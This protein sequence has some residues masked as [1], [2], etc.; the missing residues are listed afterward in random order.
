MTAS[1]MAR[2]SG[3]DATYYT[4]R[5]LARGTA[6]YM[7]LIGM[8]PTTAMPGFVSEWTFAS[9]E[10]FGLY[11]LSGEDGGFKPS[12]MVMFAVPDV[13]A[14]AA[15]CKASG[16]TMHRDVMETPSCQM[17]FGEDPDGN[18]FVLHHRT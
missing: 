18:Q 6:F 16:V 12:G 5:D 1:T 3:I 2:V 8:E 7:A 11:Q 10:S 9:G 13:A 4:V 17:A 15:A 14:A